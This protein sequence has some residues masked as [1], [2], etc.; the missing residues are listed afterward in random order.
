MKLPPSVQI[1]DH[2]ENYPIIEVQHREA[3]GRIALH[4]GHVLEWMP[5]HSDPV[6]Y[7]SP[8]AVLEHG[9]PIRGGIPVCWP[10]FGPH[11]DSAKPAHGFVRT[12]MWE[13]DRVRETPERVDLVLRIADSSESR[14]MWPFSFEARLFISMG[15]ELEVALELTNTDRRPWS[16]TGALHSYFIVG[17]VRQISLHGL[18]GTQYVEGRLSP[19]KRPQ[20]GPVLIDQEVD[21]LYASDA[22]VIVNDPVM[23]RELRIEK[24]GSLSTVVWNPW[25]EKS[26]R[27]ADLP[28]D[29][30]PEFVCVETTNAGE[31]SITLA[32]D[33]SHLLFTR[34]CVRSLKEEALPEPMLPESGLFA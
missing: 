32:P 15:L 23:A 31:D 7:M 24:S 16:F 12:Q 26:T 9:K 22:T 19:E 30:Y 17:D 20:S 21:R 1:I 27:L 10:W 3:T 5:A 4:G 18:H 2:H 33:E 25:I 11:A 14:E 29:A 6:L 34:I 8:Q 28:D 13:L